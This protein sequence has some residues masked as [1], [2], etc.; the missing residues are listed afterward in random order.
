M[1]GATAAALVLAPVLVPAAAAWDV[2][3]G[4]RR[5]PTVRAFLFV[6]QYLVND[7]V[8]ILLAGPLWVLAGFGR[9]IHHPASQRRHARLQS[10]SIGV[11]ARRA[12][13]LLGVRLDV[14]TA[15]AARLAP[16]PAVVLCRHVSVFDASLPALLY[17]RLGYH[18]RGVV[19]AE[20]LADPGFD[21]LYQRAGSIFIARDD[22]PAARDQASRVAADLDAGTVAVIFPEGRLAR[23]ELIG[24]S[25][26]RLAERAPDR[27]ARLSGLRHLLPPRP[28]GFGA[29]LDAAPDADVV[30][31]NH[32]GFDR[33]PGIRDIARHAPL[34]APIEV[35]VERYPRSAIP[36]APDARERWLD[37]LWLRMDAWV[38]DRTR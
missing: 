21:L 34:E 26:A 18:T 35:Q 14:P 11:L 33:T 10:W 24:R 8:E 16:A 6:A 2:V 32:A 29:L 12:D 31:I 5:L 30:V 17:Q 1:L 22:D 4:R 20:L 19:M 37:D 25:L 3:R 23:A 28:G 13:R 7:S 38:D 15:D 27:A 36:S 9:R